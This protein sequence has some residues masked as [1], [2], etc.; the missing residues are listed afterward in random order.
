MIRTFNCDSPRDRQRLRSGGDLRVKVRGAIPREIEYGKISGVPAVEDFPQV[1][2]EPKDFKERIEWCHREKIFAIYHQRASW[3]P[4]GVR[5]NQNGL[6]YCWAWG[7]VAALMDILA[8][9][10]RDFPMLSPV[11]LGWL[12]GWARRGNYLSSAIRGLIE[13]GVCS[14]KYTPNIHLPDPRSFREGW[15]QN[16]L[17]YRLG[18][19]EVWDLDNRSRASM[20]QH[21][22]SVLTTGTPIYIAYNWWGHALACCGVRWNPNVPYNLEWMIRNSHDEDDIII[23]TGDRAV[24]DEAYGIRAAWTFI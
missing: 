22:V 10:G 3:A 14:Q 12:V 4:P 15:E 11:S 17:E 1:L 9:E 2:V 7:I 23:M 20:V 18:Q 16:A 19:G 8:R 21:A 13:R 6:P 5:W 24:F